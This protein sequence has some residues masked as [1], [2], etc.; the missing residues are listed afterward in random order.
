[1]PG[2][3]LRVERSIGSARVPPGLRLSIKTPAAGGS[4]SEPTEVVTS[5]PDLSLPP[6]PYELS[7]ERFCV[8]LFDTKNFTGRSQVLGIGRYGMGSLVIGNDAVRSIRIPGGLVVTA[9]ADDGFTGESLVLRED[10]AE[11]PLDISSI[12]IA[13][14]RQPSRP[15]S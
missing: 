2:Q 1:M 14:Q 11:I 9:Y 10:T 4:A 7:V 12:I 8:R 3:R 5:V 6:G 13:S 15:A